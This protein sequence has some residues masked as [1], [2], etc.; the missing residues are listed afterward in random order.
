[1]NR[2]A[3]HL[4][5]LARQFVAQFVQVAQ[6]AA[7]DSVDV[8]EELAVGYLSPPSAGCSVCPVM[9]GPP[10]G[11]CRIRRCSPRT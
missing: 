9:I 1:M 10:S 2:L 4:N 8:V 6:R 5:A 11:A 3:D 7:P